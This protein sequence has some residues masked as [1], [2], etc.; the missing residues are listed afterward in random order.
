MQYGAIPGVA[1]PVSR[2]VLGTMIIS[3]E[4]DKREASFA[5]LDTAL[6]LGGN[7]FDTAH[8]YGGG[9]SERGI[10][11]WMEARGNREKV[12]IIT[13]GCHH[14]A[15][16]RR[17]TPFD[18]ESDLM[19]SLARLRSDYIDVY[20]LHRDDP[21][22]PVGVMVEALNRHLEAGRIRAFGGSN[23]SH[24]RIAEAN[25]YAE[26][27]GLVGFS[28]SSPNYGLAE[29]VL[30]PWG[31][32]C[33]SISGPREAEARRWYR[34]TNMPILAYSSLGRGFFSGRVDPD[35]PEAA[36]AILD[37]AANTA[38]AHPQNYER[39]R[40]ARALAQEKGCTIPQIALAYVLGAPLN[41][42]PLVGA[43]NGEEFR[44]NVA[45]FDIALTPRERK[46]LD[47]QVDER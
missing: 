20:L 26:A 5:L 18:L 14:N 16:R 31:P 39:L 9:H 24:Q 44:Q 11:L 34:H 30:D 37:R 36:A 42:F 17:V 40:R 33:V 27:H 22:V 3:D 7:A 8:V 29:Q 41:V 28:A 15:D 4:A 45:A 19:D 1:K 38:Y 35:H 21:D 25:A 12:V 13:K 23:W 32:G 43:V 10:G 6:A 46:W 2:L 47:L